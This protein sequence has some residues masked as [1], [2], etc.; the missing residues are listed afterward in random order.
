[1]QFSYHHPVMTAVPVSNGAPPMMP[2]PPNG[3]MAA[4]LPTP[5]ANNN[6]FTVI[7]QKSPYSSRASPQAVQRVE[8][9]D[10]ASHNNAS[11][12]KKNQTDDDN[13][14]HR[15]MTSW[16]NTREVAASVLLLAAGGHDKAT[17][18]PQD[19]ANNNKR[20]VDSTDSTDSKVPLKKR[21]MLTEVSKDDNAS[22]RVSPVS[23]GSR[24]MHAMS[25]ENTHS[26]AYDSDKHTPERSLPV[27]QVVVIH[28]PTEL[29]RLLEED[30]SKVI[31]WL[32]HGRAWRIVRWDALRKQI[33]PRCFGGT[34]VDGFLAQLADWG[35]T[36]ITDGPDAGAYY[37]PFF[38][39]NFPHLCKDM[40]YKPQGNAS[41]V[42]SPSHTSN[43]SPVKHTTPNTHVSH[44]SHAS[45]GTPSILQVP[46]LA[47]PH[48]QTGSPTSPPSTKRTMGT[49][50]RGSPQSVGTYVSATGRHHMPFWFVDANQQAV[51]VQYRPSMDDG[52]M[53]RNPSYSPVR[54]RSTRGRPSSGPVR[55][56][57]IVTPVRRMDHPESSANSTASGSSHSH[58]RYPISQRGRSRAVARPSTYVSV[59]SSMS[60]SSSH[61]THT[62]A[63][64]KATHD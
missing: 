33:L 52:S 40:Q 27:S 56:S 4:Y 61:Q 14:S 26:T 24:S 9:K 13:K 44:G 6:T 57:P 10:D 30:D 34:S 39:R 15:S 51:L 54:V 35:F 7:Q 47:S 29:Y 3:L 48:E 25:P 45:P 16:D 42:K 43:S 58:R 23:H 19:S 53:G 2:V 21:K 60:A 32:P 18:Q 11:S 63:T 59:A 20:D 1:M 64:E 12:P 50:P 55:R 37:N 22:V 17:Q 5:S 8:S 49:V 46:S 38:R 31:Q 36:E 28:F 62:A 41:P